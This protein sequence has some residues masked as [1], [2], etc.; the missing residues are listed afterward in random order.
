M[1]LY[2]FIILPLL[3]HFVFFTGFVPAAYSDDPAATPKIWTH[4]ELKAAIERTE[5]RRDFYE[6]A[7]EFWRGYDDW[8][9]S[10]DLL[11]LGCGFV[12]VGAATA[13]AAIYLSGGA[14]A[15]GVTA[16]PEQLVILNGLT[17]WGI[18]MTFP[19]VGNVFLRTKDGCWE[20]SFIVD[21]KW[22]MVRVRDQKG[23]VVSEYNYDDLNKIFS[24]PFRRL[25]EKYG[26]S[27]VQIFD[28]IENQLIQLERN[29]RVA[30]Q[31]KKSA[32]HG[33]VWGSVKSW[34]KWWWA[35]QDTAFFH[36]MA[37]INRLLQ[38][39]QEQKISAL[40]AGVKGLG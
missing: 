38:E 28:D 2:K 5:N 18:A 23:E 25:V 7:Y 1:K 36:E 31:P 29:I 35:T 32:P 14:A 8:N 3:F 17:A 30:Y 10:W 11:S 15:A 24:E 22:V 39:L 6:E 26:F 40:R 33:G 13:L 20:C 16:L 34:A 21:E 27:A 19:T 37:N 4:E 12:G 9:R